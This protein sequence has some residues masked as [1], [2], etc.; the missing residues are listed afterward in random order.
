MQF[1]V[2]SKMY[3]IFSLSPAGVFDLC[4]SGRVKEGEEET[5]GRDW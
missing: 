3:Y 4:V 2:N 5:G 1:I